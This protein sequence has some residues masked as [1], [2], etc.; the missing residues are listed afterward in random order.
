MALATSWLPEVNTL[1]G[2]FFYSF[3]F[4]MFVLFSGWL[5][6]PTMDKIME[7]DREASKNRDRGAKMR[8]ENYEIQE[9][10]DAKLA[11]FEKERL[12]KLK[13]T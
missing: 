7:D 12:E 2:F 11:Q 9:K 3:V 1:P 10:I 4:Y 6:N 5:L 13:S 8:A